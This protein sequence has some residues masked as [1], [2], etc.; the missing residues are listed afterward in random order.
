MANKSLCS[1]SKN[2]GS[3]WMWK[4]RVM[5][6]AS[7]L[8]SLPASSEIQWAQF[9]FKEALSSASKQVP[10]ERGRCDA[11]TSYHGD[12]QAIINVQDPSLRR[13]SQFGVISLSII[14]EVPPNESLGLAALQSTIGHGHPGRRPILKAKARA[15]TITNLYK[16]CKLSDLC[17][18]E[19]LWVSRVGHSSHSFS[20]THW[21]PGLRGSPLLPRIL[22]S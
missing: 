17:M 14:C 20:R 12:R 3:P 16:F 6:E 8:P 2:L 13:F 4:P 11:L 9:V 19:I 1:A 10:L 5:K 22:C 15:W 18:S 7:S 21:L